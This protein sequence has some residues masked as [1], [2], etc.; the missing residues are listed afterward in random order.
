MI[1]LLFKV[2]ISTK[3]R[4]IMHKMLIVEPSYKEHAAVSVR[5]KYFVEALKNAG[6]NVD[7][8]D[9][10]LGSKMS[11][12]INYLF[13]RTPK[14]LRRRSQETD[15]IFTSSPPPLLAITV[16]L[17]GGKYVIDV[18]DIW[19]EY[20]QQIY[21]TFLVKKIVSKY[22]KALMNANAVITTTDSMAKYYKEKLGV[23]PFVVPNGTD[24]EIIR[25]QK[26]ISRDPNLMVVLADF[27]TPYQNLDPLLEALVLNKNLKLLL[28]GS[29]KYLSP[30]LS[31]AE[32]L[33]VDSRVKSVGHVP[34][35]EISK[36]LCEAS[37]GVV[38]RPFDLN[39]EYLYTIPT[40]IYDYLA[41]GLPV[42]AYGPQDSEM[43]RFVENNGL[44]IYLIEP[45]PQEISEAALTLV[46]KAKNMR[47]H[48]LEIA[49][50]YDRKK[51][52]ATLADIV[53]KL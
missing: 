15:I 31:I 52:G 27:N 14:D 46:N 8:Y 53:S 10:N 51:L 48:I 12:L 32:K 19:E 39:P 49:N 37:I 11:R 18:R 36:Y 5:I 40:K 44:G 30:Y 17:L 43:Q 20:A 47:S 28:I 34:Y 24:T 7:V 22:F 3:G 16:S 41:A 2:R 25:C 23:D 26:E 6:L 35:N 33:G 38:G 50:K 21:P 9:Y 29:G 13:P 42:L 4:L 1:T 45:S